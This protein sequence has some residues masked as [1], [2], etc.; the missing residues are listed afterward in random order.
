MVA[1]DFDRVFVRADGAVGTETPETSRDR[2]GRRHLNVVTDR[3]REIRHVVVDTDRETRLRIVF[4][5]KIV[6][7]G[8]MHRFCV[9]RSEAVTT[10]DN[11]NIASDL[12]E[13]RGD[14]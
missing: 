1:N 10:A 14:V 5:E 7:G 2:S 3:Q 12:S 8:D 6:D 11:G 4:R 9:F 13:C